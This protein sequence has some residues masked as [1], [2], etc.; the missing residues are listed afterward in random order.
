L[1]CRAS[2]GLNMTWS[3]RL[4]FV[5]YAKSAVEAKI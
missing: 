3:Y 4:R 2:V 1:L 5:Y